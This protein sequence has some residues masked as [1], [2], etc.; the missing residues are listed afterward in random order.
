[1]SAVNDHK[2]GQRNDLEF[3]GKLEISK[4]LPYS[5]PTYSKALA[6]KHLN[7]LN[8]DDRISDLKASANVK[9]IALSSVGEVNA[10][11]GGSVNGYRRSGGKGKATAC[12]V[13]NVG[14]YAISLRILRSA[15]DLLRS[16]AD[17]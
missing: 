10:P 4:A 16:S 3:A 1:M 7:D 6:L 8:N 17:I 9:G 11:E 14:D 5:L 15:D 2:R 12:A 13:T